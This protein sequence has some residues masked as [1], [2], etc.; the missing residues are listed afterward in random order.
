MSVVLGREDNSMGKSLQSGTT[1]CI[2][3]VSRAFDILEYLSYSTASLGISEIAKRFQINRTTTYSLV[4]SLIS[5][6]YL[7]RDSAGKYRVTSR[8]FELGVVFQNQFPA[9]HCIKRCNLSFMSAIPCA[10]K[11]AILTNDMRALIVYSRST[12]D[13]LVQQIGRAHV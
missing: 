10:C 5:K 4:N 7:Y 11:L 1:E 3:S 9:V 12:E 6:G 2:S 8:T 13:A